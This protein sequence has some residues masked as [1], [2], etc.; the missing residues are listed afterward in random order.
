MFENLVIWVLTT[1]VLVVGVLAALALF[2][3]LQL[4]ARLQQLIRAYEQ[5]QTLVLG[6]RGAIEAVGATAAEQARL[7]EEAREAIERLRDQHDALAA[8]DPENERYEQAIRLAE[9]GASRAE[10]KRVCQLSEAELDLIV[11]LHPAKR[12]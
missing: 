4:R 1:L 5:Q 10:I 8:R 7:Q 12:H 2:G 11:R 3:L 6:L 9:G